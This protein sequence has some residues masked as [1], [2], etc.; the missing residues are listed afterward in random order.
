MSRPLA[1]GALARRLCASTAPSQVRAHGVQAPGLSSSVPRGSDVVRCRRNGDWKALPRVK[2]F[3]VKKV[4][5][6]GPTQ[7]RHVS[8]QHD[9]LGDHSQCGAKIRFRDRAWALFSHVAHLAGRRCPQ[10][11]RPQTHMQLSG[12]NP[13]SVWHLTDTPSPAHPKE[14]CESPVHGWRTKSS[15]L[16]QAGLQQEGQIQRYGQD[17]H[18]HTHTHKR[19]SARIAPG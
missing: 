7:A 9:R 3:L 18:S 17:I 14:V 15:P 12:Q 4:H 13:K 16:L 19:T 1:V 8:G 6:T 11:F 10:D 2:R 5:Q